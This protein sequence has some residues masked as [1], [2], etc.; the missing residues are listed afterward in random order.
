MQSPERR[1]QCETGAGMKAWRLQPVCKA[2]GAD[3]ARSSPRDR[4]PR[5]LRLFRMDPIRLTV[6]RD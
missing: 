1:E 4:A 2:E 6:K 5:P 3:Y